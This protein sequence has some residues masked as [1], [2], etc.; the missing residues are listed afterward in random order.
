MYACSLQAYTPFRWYKWS[1]PFPFRFSWIS[2]DRTTTPDSLL[3]GEYQAPGSKLP[4][5][6][7]KYELEWENGRRLKTDKN[8]LAT[9]KWA[10]CVNINGMQGGVEAHGK[11]YI[12]RSNGS[13]KGDMFGWVPGK[14][15]HLNAGL[16]PRSPE[17]LSYD[18][19]RGG[20]IYTLTEAPK[21]RYIIDMAASKV[22][23]S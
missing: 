21:V 11:V 4:I 8:G 18:K 7:A 10:R 17:D 3:V 12:S 13:K 19:R 20:R 16:L 6:M 23:F 5:R 14:A 15:A 1:S 2:L 9:A 22:K